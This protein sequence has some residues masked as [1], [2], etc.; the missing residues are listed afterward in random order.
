MGGAAAVVLVV[1]EATLPEV[2]VVMVLVLP[3]VARV[4]H[5]QAAVPAVPVVMEVI[6]EIMAQPA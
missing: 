2:L 3:Q 1:R 6:M 4:V 5:K